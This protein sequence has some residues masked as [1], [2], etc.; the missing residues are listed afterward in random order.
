VWLATV[1]LLRV[2]RNWKRAGAEDRVSS[3]GWTD[4]GSG[5]TAV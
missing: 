5:S 4:G 1:L 2:R 3:K